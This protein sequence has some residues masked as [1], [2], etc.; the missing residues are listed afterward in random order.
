MRLAVWIGYGCRGLCKHIHVMVG[1]DGDMLVMRRECTIS[2]S[3]SCLD[4]SL[5]HA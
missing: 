1:R 5:S 2:L 4:L 3:L